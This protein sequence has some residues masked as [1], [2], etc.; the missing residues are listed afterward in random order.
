MCIR[1]RSRG[2][3]VVGEP[4][5]LQAFDETAAK[6]KICCNCKKSHCLKLYCQCFINKS[7]CH[8]CNCINCFNTKEYEEMRNETMRLTLQRNPMAFEPKISSA[9][10]TV[11]L[12]KNYRGELGW[13]ALE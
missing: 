11:L 8:G 7:Y 12:L 10:L 5:N 1:D 3:G 9:E 2:S 4:G 13:P 6:R